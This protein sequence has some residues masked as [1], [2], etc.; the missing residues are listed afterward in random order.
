MRAA[1]GSA[2][3]NW[4][5]VVQVAY[6]PRGGA[7]IDGVVGDTIAVEIE[8][9]VS[10]QVRGAVLDLICHAYPKK[11]LVIIPVHMSNPTLC[12]DQCANIL[13]KFLRPENY[14]VIVLAGSGPY[15]ELQADA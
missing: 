3:R 9:R 6:G 14:R 5:P 8:S 4:G 2:F 1:A 11:L 12:S 10:K 15:Q 13:G 7:S